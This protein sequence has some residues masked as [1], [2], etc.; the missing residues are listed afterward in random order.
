MSPVRSNKN[1]YRG[2]NAHL[3]SLLQ[4][5]GGW[6]GFHAN[7]IPDLTRLLQVQLRPMGYEADIEQSLQIR[8]AGEFAKYPKSDVTVYDPDPVRRLKP[9]GVHQAA[10][11]ELVMPIPAMLN[12][13][14]ERLDY[15]KAIGIYKMASSGSE[16]GEPIVW[17]ELLSPSN[18]PPHAD[19]V[20][21][22]EKRTEVLQSGIVFVEIDYLHEFPPTFDSVPSYRPLDRSH[23]PEP[24]AHPYRITVLE[25]RPD[26]YEGQGRSR[27]FVVDEPIP[28]MAI[29]LS[30][31]DAIEFDFGAP[32]QK[33]FEEMFYGDR[34]DYSQLPMNFDLYSEADQTRIVSRML[35]VLAAS[36]NGEDLERVAPLPVQAVSL[37]AGLARLQAFPSTT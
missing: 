16:R 33:T 36:Q 10:A 25:P 8:R 32:Y 24:G 29:P 23:P 3:H 28:T 1:Q 12:L 34:V 19:F 17:I 6:N 35:A 15:Y 9:V 2:I 30:A 20:H 31:G 26:F 13:A 21:Y 18:K 27:Q 22:H 4:A 11:D 14:E 7:H 37:E 5:K